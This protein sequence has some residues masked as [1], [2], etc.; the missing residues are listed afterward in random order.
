M[1]GTVAGNFQNPQAT[2]KKVASVATGNTSPRLGQAGL[3]MRTAEG[4]AKLGFYGGCAATTNVSASCAQQDAH[5][6]GT[7]SGGGW[8]D[9]AACPSARIGAAFVPNL[10][11]LFND[12]AFLLFGL[13]PDTNATN[14]YELGSRGEIDVLS[15]SQG[16]WSRVLPSCDPSSTP[17]CP[18]PREGAVV[19][20][21]A[22]TIAWMGGSSAASAASDIIVFGGKDKDGNVLNDAWILRATTAQITYTNQTNWDALYGNGVLG[23]G[24]GT[25][26][27]GVTVEVGLKP[28]I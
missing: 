20:S 13:A 9:I 28:E 22:N 4:E 6:V 14:T 17:P 2:W 23:S 21:S 10:N 26:G 3:V 12:M 25:N 7:A 11:H 24:V 16:T 19:V 8:D 15:I 1:S 27:Q 18:I 5:I